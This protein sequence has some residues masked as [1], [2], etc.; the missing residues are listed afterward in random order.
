MIIFGTRRKFETVGAGE[1]YC[2]HCQRPRAYEHQRG[3]NY[4]ALY[5]IP[6]FPIGS[7]GEFIQCTHCG[8]SYNLE[9]LDFK[10]K[11]TGSDVNELLN[12]VKRTLD[13]GT[14]IEYV[15]SDLTAERLDREIAFNTARLVT[16]GTVRKC[17]NCD[18]T[19]APSVM[20]CPACRVALD[21]P[22][23]NK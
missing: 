13:R 10:P 11:H 17:P 9:V 19:Y 12:R 4:F 16:G 23:E 6:L 1:F 21:A 18:L 8:M 20:E 22:V 5:F 14:P 3:R 15:I 2:P 7:S